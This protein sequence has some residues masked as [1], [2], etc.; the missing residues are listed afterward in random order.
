ML[1][2]KICEETNGEVLLSEK[3]QIYNNYQLD[4]NHQEFYQ[5]ETFLKKGLFPQKFLN[6]KISNLNV[7]TI[8][9]NEITPVNTSILKEI[10]I[11]NIY[12]F[13]FQQQN[14]IFI[15]HGIYLYQHFDKT[16]Y[17]LLS[18]KIAI[19]NNQIKIFIINHDQYF[20]QQ[21]QIYKIINETFPKY[22]KSFTPF[23]DK[24]RLESGLTQHFMFLK[25]NS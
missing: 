21:K 4:K 10:N 2:K 18:P 3:M 16:N 19:Q 11:A 24:L 20:Q 15:C 6:L 12:P 17:L 14:K 9:Y 1:I 23:S 13:I 25:Q 5:L 8:N 22:L 7:L